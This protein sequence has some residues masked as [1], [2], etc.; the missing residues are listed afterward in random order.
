M[1]KCHSNEKFV[2]KAETKLKDLTFLFSAS[3]SRWLLRCVPLK[4]P[5]TLYCFSH[6]GHFVYTFTLPFDLRLLE[7]LHSDT[8][9]HQGLRRQFDL[10]IS[11]DTSTSVV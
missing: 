6:S 2:L 11:D 3:M 5:Y 9:P 8:V 1:N 10:L 4:N 7:V